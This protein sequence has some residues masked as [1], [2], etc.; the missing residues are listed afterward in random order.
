MNQEFNNIIEYICQRDR[1]YKPDAY[2]FVMEALSFTQKKFQ[3]Q[4]HVTGNEL[5]Q[6][7]KDLLLDKFGPMTLVILKH[8]GVAQAED[9]GNI[10]F[11]LVSNKILSKTEE[12]TIE[13]FKKGY[14]F[15]EAFGTGYR[16]QL[17]KRLSRMRSF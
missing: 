17:H 3:R 13:S 14:D 16:K 2:E 10:V 9:F 4:K 5:L 8:W 12:D 1:R 7:I 15:E 6:G 11:N